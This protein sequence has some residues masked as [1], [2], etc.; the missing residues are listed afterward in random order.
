MP[1]SVADQRRLRILAAVRAVPAGQ[2]ASYGTI[3]RRAGFPRN[4]RLVAQLLAAS[5]DPDLP[6][7]RIVRSD[8]RIGLPPGSPGFREQCE[9]LRVE[10]VMVQAGRARMQR[11]DD[12]WL[13]EIL[14]GKNP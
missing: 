9:R 13:D 1:E 2:V 7:H 11:E 14:W 10:G 8:G 6:W 5:D 12:H 4:A 3:A